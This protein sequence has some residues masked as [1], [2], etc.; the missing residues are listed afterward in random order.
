MPGAEAAN[1]S[2]AEKVP[3]SDILQTV[4]AALADLF[5]TTGEYADDIVDRLT[6]G[7]FGDQV[8][9]EQAPASVLNDLILSI[10]KELGK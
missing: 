3:T 5:E 7:K 2:P 9:L 10:K 6:G 1:E 4:Y 8:A